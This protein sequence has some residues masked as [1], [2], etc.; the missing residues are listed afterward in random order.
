MTLSQTNYIESLCEKF[1][2]Q[3]AKLYNTPM[4]SNLHIDPAENPDPNLSFRNLIGALLYI[5]SA[6]RPDITYSV[7]YLS[8]FTTCA[9]ETHYK[10]ALRILK[11]LLMSKNLKLCFKKSNV[12]EVLDSFVDSDWAGDHIDRK[13]TSGYVIRFYGNPIYWKTRKQ[14]FVTKS[15]THAEYIALSEATSEILF[16]LNLLETFSINVKNKINIYEDNSGA[17][18][19]AKLGNLTR[20]SK[21]IEVNFHFVNENYKKGVIDIVKISSDENMGDIFTK[22]L[23]KEKF[24]KFRKML[25]IGEQ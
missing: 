9:D 25:R 19:I 15:S 18:T 3:N 8:R 4:E 24:F 7:N 13:S 20:N 5:S 17:L 14:N 21:H 6:T 1:Q 23:P 16:V 10:Y 22:A 12:D 2:I 11:Y